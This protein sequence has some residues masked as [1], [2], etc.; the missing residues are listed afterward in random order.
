MAEVA[1]NAPPAA[2]IR[3][4]SGKAAELFL[5]PPF[6]SRA[7]HLFRRPSM[8]MV[9]IGFL[10]VM[11]VTDVDISVSPRGGSDLPINYLSHSSVVVSEFNCQSRL[12]ERA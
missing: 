3:A 8:E 6:E 1:T 5:R 12:S 7:E 11:V 9:S 2:V 10:A 4:M